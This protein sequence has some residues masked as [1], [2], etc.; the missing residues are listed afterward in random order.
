MLE[1]P[2]GCGKSSIIKYIE[3]KLAGK[4]T[5]I[6]VTD[7][8]ISGPN[9]IAEIYQLA[10]NYAPTIVVLED[11]DTIGLTRERSSNSFTS[12][13]LGQ[14]DG[15]EAL[16]GVVTIATTN[17][18][19]LIDDALKNRP[20][21]F[22]RRIQI[23]IPDEHM[24]KRMLEAFLAE[25]DIHLTN[26]DIEELVNKTVRFSGAMLKE[27]VITAKMM[28]IQQNLEIINTN[29]IK[30]AISILKKTFNDSDINEA[31][32]IGLRPR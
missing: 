23:G 29:T 24:R 7:G 22:D 27:L 32:T 10:R 17:Y 16:E 28:Q 26:I 1:G 5:I 31:H 8:I 25:R 2:P 14:L 15:L 4:V 9:D 6:Y 19:D 18:P 13:L 11:I 30:E 21:R 3:S 12:E 20:S